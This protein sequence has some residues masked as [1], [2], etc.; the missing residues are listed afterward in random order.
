MSDKRVQAMAM[1]DKYKNTISLSV[2]AFY[3]V[4]FSTTVYSLD[5]EHGLG[6]ALSSGGSV[7]VFGLAWPQSS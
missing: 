1:P 7:C 5:L 6:Q 2:V 3:N 4:L